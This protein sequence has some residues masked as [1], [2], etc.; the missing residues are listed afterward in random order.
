ML[1]LLVDACQTIGARPLEDVPVPFSS[2]L[3]APAPRPDSDATDDDDDEEG[4]STSTLGGKKGPAAPSSSSSSSSN[5]AS[6]AGPAAAQ[7]GTK[8][9]ALTQQSLLPVYDRIFAADPGGRVAEW[10]FEVGDVIKSHHGP[11][12]GD[13]VTSRKHDGVIV[14]SR[15]RHQPPRRLILGGAGGSLQS[16]IR[17]GLPRLGAPDGK[18][19]A[20]KS[21]E[22]ETVSK[23]L[24]LLKG[25]IQ[26]TLHVY[27][28]V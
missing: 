20:S 13:D 22:K 3:W 12:G 15:G 1:F 25:L 9:S 24:L 28:C 2:V 4:P 10:R 26:V 18:A 16:L 11:S 6:T 5:P 27:S 17:S 19:D 14:E 21:S 23:L 7:D 8:P